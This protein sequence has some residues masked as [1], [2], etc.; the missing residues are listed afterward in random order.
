[1][2]K[3][4][5]FLWVIASMGAYTQTVTDYDGNVYDEIGIGAQT[6]IKQNLNSVHY[7][8]GTDIPDV[9]AYNNSDSMAQIYGRL[10]TWDA[11]MRESKIESTQGV[12]PEGWHVPSSA[13]WT[14]LEN[15]LG[16]ATSAGGAMKETG[17]DH[18]AS[19]NTGATNSSGF[20]GLGAGEFDAYY[21][22]YIFQYLYTAAVFWTS[23]EVSGTKA[24]ERYLSHDNASCLPYNWYKV[25]KYSIRC[26][27]DGPTGVQKME[28]H[29]GMIIPNPVE[30]SFQ[31]HFDAEIADAMM[32]LVDLSGRKMISFPVTE[33]NGHY[34]VSHLTAGLYLVYLTNGG[35]H[36]IT[37]LIKQ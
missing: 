32:E 17:T 21:T 33:K 34:D 15:F 14:T 19:P 16:G 22:P 24:T 35:Y 18:W 5:L 1:M 31:L 3:F 6:W 12:C 7:S 23:T 37:Y 27:K 30:H 25:M 26:I 8:D 28:Y 29:E 11:T 13:E 10:Y 36:F 9:V 4:I 2:K 20:T